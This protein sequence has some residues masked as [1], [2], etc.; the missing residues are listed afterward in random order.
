MSKPVGHRVEHVP[1]KI[2]AQPFRGLIRQCGAIL[3][4]RH[5][6]NPVFSTRRVAEA[7]APSQPRSAGGPGQPPVGASH[8]PSGSAF[9]HL[10]VGP[11]TGL[12]SWPL[13][14][15]TRVLFREASTDVQAWLL[16]PDLH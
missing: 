3:G 16:R 9:N 15:F 1:A 14:G 11:G 13:I 4:R 5:N 6:E 12:V 8:R 2:D 7:W 10:Q